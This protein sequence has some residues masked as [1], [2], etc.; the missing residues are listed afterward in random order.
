MEAIV[1]RLAVVPPIPVRH[2]DKRKQVV[3]VVHAQSGHVLVCIGA[4]RGSTGTVTYLHP[5]RARR[6]PQPS[7]FVT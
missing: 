2:D 3:E 7:T 5:A 4:Q 1:D 6:Q